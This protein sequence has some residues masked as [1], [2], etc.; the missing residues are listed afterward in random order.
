MRIVLVVVGVDDEQPR[1]GQSENRDVA[2]DRLVLEGRLLVDQVGDD[3]LSPNAAR[4][5]SETMAGW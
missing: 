1:L 5:T 3:G 4:T 2:T